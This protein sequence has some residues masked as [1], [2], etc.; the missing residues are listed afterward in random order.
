[1]LH[2]REFILTASG[3]ALTTGRRNFVVVIVVF[4]VLGIEPTSLSC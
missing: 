1:M 4:A 3:L 2:M